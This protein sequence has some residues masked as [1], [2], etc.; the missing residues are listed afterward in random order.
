LRSRSVSLEDAVVEVLKRHMPD[1]L[2]GSVRRRAQAALGVEE[3]KL[4]PHHMARL[5]RELKNGLRLFADPKIH[6]AV[7]AELEALVTLETQPSE[8]VDIRSEPDIS[9][10]R[11]RAR[12]LVTLLGGSSF[13][14]Q[15]AATVTSELS[16]N[17]VSYA[18]KGVVE[19]RPHKGPPARLTVVA[20]DE[21]PGI[22]GVD[23]ILAGDYKS[24]TG[25]GKGLAGVKKLS[26]RF[27]VQTASTGTRVEAEVLVQ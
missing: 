11:M 17:I 13:A 25:M 10:A 22:R 6:E 12:E 18:T 7:L 2:A 3:G 20:I 26:N 9:R 4:G 23:A 21:G 15:R 24:K 5:T 16:R 19:L 1:I 27:D 8:R 14:A